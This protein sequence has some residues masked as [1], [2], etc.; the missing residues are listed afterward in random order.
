M[1]RRDNGVLANL[2]WV[3]VAIFIVLVLCGWLS[4]YSAGYSI[5]ENEII[6]FS[7]NAG[8]QLV[9]ILCSFVLAA[10][11]LSFSQNLYRSYS[12]LLYAAFIL[13]LLVTIVIADDTKGSRSWISLGP[14]KLQPAEFAKFATALA[15]AKFIDNDDFNPGKI[16][17]I[18]KAS[19]FF[20]LPLMLII[21]QKETGSAL[22]YL[23]FFLVLYREGMSG[24]P[25]FGACCAV[26]FF[27]VGVK[28]WNVP[29][30]D[31]PFCVGP[32]VVMILIQLLSALLMLVYLPGRSTWLPVLII[33]AG[34]TVL[35]LIVSFMVFPFNV[36]V[37]QVI[38]IALMAV[39]LLFQAMKNALGQ[40]LITLAFAVLSTIY[41]FSCN[42]VFDHVLQPHQ[43]TRVNII[44]GIEDDPFGAGYNVNQSMI[45]IGS[46]GFW[47][48][49]FLNGTQTKL[50]YVPE[51]YTDFIFCTIGEEQGFKGTLF[52]MILYLVFILRLMW[53]AERQS[54]VFG[55]AFGYAVAC[56]FLFH[57][58]INIGM[59]LGITPVIGIPLP[60]FSYGGSSLFGFTIL[61]FILLRIDTERTSRF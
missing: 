57:L 18:L 19:A 61:L 47:G 17:S 43:Q 53:L 54:S 21:C 29:V 11:V 23:A 4:I 28:F 48:K 46:G 3:T 51:Q 7:T 52:V 37:L 15:L 26:L 13:L 5:E 39:F 59:V 20:M 40:C 56:I 10:V 45:A 42:F 50:K 30:G 2:D 6:G 35:G 9:W 38:S 33:G 16:N 8:K 34:S 14:M 58:F 49:G 27:I 1:E 55:R 36:V 12:F 25:L 32:F 41:L 44:L 31:M 24:L 60:F 22:V